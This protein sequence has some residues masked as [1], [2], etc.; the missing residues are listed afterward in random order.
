[1]ALIQVPYE[2]P[3]SPQAQTFTIQLGTITYNL[4]V[5]WN[6]APMGGWVL[7]ILDNNSDPV[8]TGIPLVTGVN[9]LE[10]YDY[11]G[12]QG[13][14]QVQTDFDPDEI[15]TFQNLGIQSHLYFITVVEE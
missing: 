14:L 11:L 2:I 13:A 1:M 6:D 7:D 15:P 3:L 4:V 8:V 9:L 10:Q 5:A 12:F